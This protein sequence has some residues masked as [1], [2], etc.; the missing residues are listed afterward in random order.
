MTLLKKKYLV[1]SLVH[2]VFNQFACMTPST[3]TICIQDKKL[4]KRNITK[5]SIHF[6]RVILK[7]TSTMAPMAP[8]LLDVGEAKANNQ[9]SV[10]WSYIM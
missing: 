5:P 10:P 1:I 4:I 6:E 9:A 8:I 3:F 7:Y 2:R